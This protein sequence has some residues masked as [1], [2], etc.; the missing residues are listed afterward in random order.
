MFPN[1]RLGAD[2]IKQNDLATSD[3]TITNTFAFDMDYSLYAS[4]W[5]R[6]RGWILVPMVELV[7]RL[8]AKSEAG[9]ELE[10]DIGS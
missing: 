1:V 7:F 10:N 6:T 9:Q 8:V 3:T 2:L 4:D 5:C